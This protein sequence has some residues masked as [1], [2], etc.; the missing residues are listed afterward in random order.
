MFLAVCAVCGK[1]AIPAQF[2]GHNPNFLLNIFYVALRFSRPWLWDRYPLLNVNLYNHFLFAVGREY[3]ALR[4][5]NHHGHIRHI[6]E[7][8]LG[9]LMKTRVLPG[10]E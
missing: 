10:D 8:R 6:L 1:P 2:Q 9:I 3:A 7:R 5:D 4:S